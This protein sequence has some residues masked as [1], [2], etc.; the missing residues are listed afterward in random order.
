MLMSK[1][2]NKKTCLPTSGNRRKNASQRASFMKV[3]SVNLPK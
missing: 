3:M 1:S 2:V